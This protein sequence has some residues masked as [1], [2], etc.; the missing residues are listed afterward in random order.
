[1]CHFELIF[2]SVAFYLV[3]QN[4]YY[5]YS[6]VVTKEAEKVISMLLDPHEHTSTTHQKPPFGGYI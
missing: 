2:F 6:F 5:K 3:S 4:F 1:M